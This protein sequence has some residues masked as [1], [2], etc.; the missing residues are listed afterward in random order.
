MRAVFAF[1]TDL[2]EQL[3]TLIP[4]VVHNCDILGFVQVN[5]LRLA[6][7]NVERKT[8][9]GLIKKVMLK[10]E[11]DG[12]TPVHFWVENRYET[13][14]AQERLHEHSIVFRFKDDANWRYVFTV[15]QLIKGELSFE[16]RPSE[17][18]VRLVTRNFERLGVSSY[19]LPTERVNQ[20]SL[21]ELGKSLV[22]QPN[23]FDE[24]AAYCVGDDILKQLQQ[25]VAQR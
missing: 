9:D 24:V 17:P 20:Q 16:P 10:F 19:A 14:T 7:Y 5:G 2:A 12:V 6:H 25:K 15:Q 1:L 22:Q 18:G 23:K 8:G 11:C 3:N 4:E 13:A 21:D